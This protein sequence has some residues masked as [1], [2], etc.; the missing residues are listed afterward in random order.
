LQSN[1]FKSV[2]FCL[3]G[4]YAARRAHAVA[5][6]AT[7]RGDGSVIN[8]GSLLGSTCIRRFWT[9]SKIGAMFGATAK[10]YYWGCT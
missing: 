3:L 8:L 10:D 4:S 1:P 7:D 5:Q 2:I 6:A 9:V